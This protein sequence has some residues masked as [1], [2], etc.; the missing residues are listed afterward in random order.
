[1]NLQCIKEAIDNSV[2]QNKLDVFF[3]EVLE[4]VIVLI[5]ENFALSRITSSHIK[6]E[7]QVHH[8]VVDVGSLRQCVINIEIPVVPKLLPVI[9]KAIMLAIGEASEVLRKHHVVNSR[10]K[11]IQGSH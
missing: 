2:A 1:L 3:I 8:L 11:S 4:K 5:A 9:S 10:A 7:I 6:K